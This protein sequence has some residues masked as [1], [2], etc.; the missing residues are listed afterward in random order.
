MRRYCSVL[1]GLALAALLAGGCAMRSTTGP[2]APPT[3]SDRIVCL[4]DSITDGHTL[5]LMVRQAILDANEAPPVFINAGI[6]GDTAANMHRR[7]NRDVLAQHPTLVTLSVGVNDVLR[8]VPLA[9][10]EADADAIM[11]QMKA[12]GIPMLILTTTLLGGKKNEAAVK[13]E[14]DRKMEA[15]DRRLADY[16][17]VLRRLAARYGFRVAEVNAL[18]REARDAHIN[19][20][21]PDNVHLNLDGYRVMARAVLDALGYRKAPVPTELRL[22]VMPGILRQW[23][24]AVALKPLDDAA[25][26]ALRVDDTWQDLTLPQRGPMSPHW[27]P[28]QERQRG[29]AQEL[30]KL[31]GPSDRFTAVATIEEPVRR[32]VYLNTGA[33]L[34]KIWLNGKRVYERPTEY[35]G[36]HA[37]RE[38]VPAELKAGTN[39]VVI[40]TGKDFFLSITDS[41]TW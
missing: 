2:V 30:D 36:W 28:E 41:D 7:V 17:A 18:M 8:D 12:N 39:T 10:Y 31:A 19:V 6:G 29:F 27:W 11:G 15:A 25:A 9:S 34:E 33:G 23:K 32:K 4:G 40:V 35:T 5:I 21:E 20:L 38:R 3:Q 13:T 24:V 1:A 16:N 22:E 37:G 26:A 14:A